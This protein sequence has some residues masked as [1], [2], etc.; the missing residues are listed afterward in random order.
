MKT[1]QE[2]MKSDFEKSQSNKQIKARKCL[3]YVVNHTDYISS[4]DLLILSQHLVDVQ[5]IRSKL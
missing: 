3:I 4:D 5:E 1:L 2:K